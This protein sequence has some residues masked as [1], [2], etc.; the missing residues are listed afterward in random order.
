MSN[1]IEILKHQLQTVN[2]RLIGIKEQFNFIEKEATSLVKR[3]Q[4]LMQKIEA[5]K[6]GNND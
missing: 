6:K 5:L 4:T 1:D 2:I 3:R